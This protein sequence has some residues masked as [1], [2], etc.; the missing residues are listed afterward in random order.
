IA[1][2][3]PDLVVDV[4]PR[5]RLG[6][7]ADVLQRTVDADR[8]DRPLGMTRLECLNFLAYPPRLLEGATIGDHDERLRTMERRAQG[9]SNSSPGGAS[10]SLKKTVKSRS[11]SRRARSDA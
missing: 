3:E 11:R 2:I 5:A 8:N 6:R 9:T 10:S 4:Q 1:F 7:K